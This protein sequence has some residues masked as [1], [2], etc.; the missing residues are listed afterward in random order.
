[1]AVSI[2]MYSMYAVFIFGQNLIVK[3]VFQSVSE[4]VQKERCPFMLIPTTPGQ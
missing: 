4:I 3:H 1:M 2:F